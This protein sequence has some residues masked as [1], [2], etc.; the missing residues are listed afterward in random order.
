MQNRTV[1]SE[2]NREQEASFRAI[3]GALEGLPVAEIEGLRESAGPYLRFR[4][5]VDSYQSERFDPVCRKACFETGLSACCG[6]ES[7]YTFFADQ[8]IDFLFSSPEEKATLF[9]VLN[10]PNLTGKCVYLGDNGCLWKIRPISCA[11]FLCDEAKKSAFEKRPEEAAVWGEFRKREK[12]F[13]FPDKP[14]LFDDLETYFIGL[15][16]ES[17]YMYFHRSAGLLRV[18]E[19][20]GLI[21]EKPVR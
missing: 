21:D 18:K 7:I 4:E 19:K 3:G 13:T 1:I 17:A 8:T 9:E 5:D 15:G 6:F 10:R 20:H 14:V 11:M 2:Y 12:D 16:V